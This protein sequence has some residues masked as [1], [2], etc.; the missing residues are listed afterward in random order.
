MTLIPAPG[1]RGR[2]ISINSRLAQDAQANKNAYVSCAG[3][4]SALLQSQQRQRP[5]WWTKRNLVSKQN[6]T[7][8]RVSAWWSGDS[9]EI[10]D[11]F[12]QPCWSAQKARSVVSQLS[13]RLNNSRKG[14]LQEVAGE[15]GRLQLQQF[16]HSQASHQRLQGSQLSFFSWQTL[17]FPMGER[18][19][20]TNKQFCLLKVRLL[21][22]CLLHLDTAL[23]I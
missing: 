7:N 21:S 3:W 9:Y 18:L 10:I 19:P 12:A 5:A 16:P 8:K 15:T 22:F 1:C 6:K 13:F 14:R 2:W 11:D 23:E 4:C 17:C 20:L